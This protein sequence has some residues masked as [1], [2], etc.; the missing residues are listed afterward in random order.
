MHV[1][2]RQRSSHIKYQFL[3]LLASQLSTKENEAI[4]CLN[5]SQPN[6]SFC[7][8]SVISLRS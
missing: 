7:V 3:F 2:L 5:M 8:P 1:S 4:R 6:D